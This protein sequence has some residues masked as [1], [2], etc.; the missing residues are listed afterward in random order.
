[1]SHRTLYQIKVNTFFQCKIRARKVSA[2][3]TNSDLVN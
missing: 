1:M 3:L 2:S